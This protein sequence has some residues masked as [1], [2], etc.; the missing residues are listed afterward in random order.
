MTSYHWIGNSYDVGFLTNPSLPA[1]NLNVPAGATMRRFLTRAHEIY[2][3]RHGLGFE[4]GIPFAMGNFVSITAGQYAGRIL[5]QDSRRIPSTTV[6]HDDPT[7]LIGFYTVYAFG[8]DSDISFN[9]KCAYGT[10]DGP[11]F[12]VTYNSGITQLVGG[13]K[14]FDGTARVQFRVLYSLP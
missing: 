1:I 12:T 8:G 7:S 4:Y 9:Q 5:Y 14:P 11:G 6:V 2:I 13:T 3:I 10:A